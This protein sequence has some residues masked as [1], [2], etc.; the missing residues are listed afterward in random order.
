M[1]VAIPRNK[2]IPSITPYLVSV[3]S[4]ST[5]IPLTATK[6]KLKI[7]SINIQNTM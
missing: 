5:Y 3:N 1:K 4:L 7:I 6:D 2:I